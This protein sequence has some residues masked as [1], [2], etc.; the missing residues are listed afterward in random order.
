MS[1]PKTIGKMGRVETIYNAASAISREIDDLRH[2]VT[3]L[4]EG[5][6]SRDGKVR[7]DPDP[8]AGEVPV[9]P[10][11]IALDE[12]PPVLHGYAK[13]ICEIR[14]LLAERLL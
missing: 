8:G 7:P 6:Y 10:L 1:E 13:S 4:V 9:P 12:L 14:S 11:G 5:A 2:F 3:K